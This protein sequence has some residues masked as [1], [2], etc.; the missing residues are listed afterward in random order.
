MYARIVVQTPPLWQIALS[1]LIMV[2]TIA[3]LVV[4][5]A[6]IYRIGVL[7]YGKRATLPEIMK[8]LKYAKA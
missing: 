7:I 1:L 3:G 4:L 8:W 6:R 5:C 2:A